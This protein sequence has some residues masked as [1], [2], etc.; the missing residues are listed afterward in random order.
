ML[1][2]KEN[3]IEFE[4][5]TIISELIKENLPLIS[6]SIILTKKELDK[7]TLKDFRRYNEFSLNIDIHKSFKEKFHCILDLIFLSEIHEVANLLSYIDEQ[8][9]KFIQNVPDKL[10]QRAKTKI[11]DVVLTVDINLYDNN[12]PSFLNFFGEI[13]AINHILS[14]P[15]NRY[16]I[17]DIEYKLKNG[18]SID[19][20]IY[21]NVFKDFLLIEIM[22]IHFQKE[23]LLSYTPDEFLKFLKQRISDK[24]F[25][26]TNLITN[27]IVIKILPIIWNNIEDMTS[28]KSVIKNIDNGVYNFP[29]MFLLIQKDFEG[30]N[31]YQFTSINSYFNSM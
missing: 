20:S 5:K 11:K 18:K 21:D 19:F 1:H 30:I 27:N 12:N 14:S 23:K 24:Y 9:Y 22:N 10:K 17:E 29:V 7:L 15:D 2:P 31:L 3:S 13:I 25:D 8:C 16:F 6:K 4:Y 28:F 26:K